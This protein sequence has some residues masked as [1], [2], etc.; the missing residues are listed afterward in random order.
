MKNESM[1]QKSRW[2]GTEVTKA[3]R[4]KRWRTLP[5]Y[6]LQGGITAWKKQTR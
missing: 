6:C 4:F 1:C 3:E 5:Q 2:S